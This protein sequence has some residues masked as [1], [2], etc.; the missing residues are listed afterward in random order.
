MFL[1]DE[2]K[3]PDHPSFYNSERDADRAIQALAEAR[4][5]AEEARLLRNHRVDPPSDDERKEEADSSGA[6]GTDSPAV[7]AAPSESVPSEKDENRGDAEAISE[8]DPEFT[9]SVVPAAVTDRYE[10]PE[11]DP[12][13]FGKE[14]E[15]ASPAFIQFDP[16]A[17][18]ALHRR[19]ARFGE[20]ACERL[21]ALAV[22]IFDRDGLPLYNHPAGGIEPNVSPVL[23]DLANQANRCLGLRQGGTVQVGD[24]SG[25]WRCVLPWEDGS[26]SLFAG[27]LL[28]RPLE[29]AEIEH[30]TKALA[31]AIHPTQ[32]SD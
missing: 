20:E 21:G 16:G 29:Q 32:S 27:L 23:V 11:T 12:L 31:H 15:P 2:L 22:A 10:L 8:N 26:R 4:S 5:R 14:S 9:G 6:I 19:I 18:R 13:P 7:T 1:R 3:K 17:D 30:W 28:G 24:L 25:G